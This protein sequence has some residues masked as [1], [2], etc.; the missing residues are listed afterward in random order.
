MLVILM[1]LYTIDTTIWPYY[2]NITQPC[3]DM[4]IFTACIDDNQYG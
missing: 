4:P 3:T 1:I 2:R